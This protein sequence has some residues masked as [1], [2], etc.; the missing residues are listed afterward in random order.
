MIGGMT[1]SAP[2]ANGKAKRRHFARNPTSAYRPSGGSILGMATAALHG[3]PVFT[4]LDIPLM[5]RDP[6]VRFISALWRG[7]FQ[8]VRWKVRGS[9]EK[10]ANFVQN[11]LRRFWRGGVPRILARYFE[12]G[13]GAGGVEFAVRRGWVRL[14]KVRPL[15]CQDVEPRV[16]A[17]D[18]PAL[19][20]R[21]GAFAGVRVRGVERLVAPP[22]AM[23]FA[24]NQRFGEWYDQSPLS[25]MFRPWLE[26]N[27]RGGAIQQRVKWF[28][29]HASSGHTIRYPEGTTNVGPDENPEERN[30]QDLARETLDY[31]ETNSGFILSN[32]KQPTAD[33]KG[34]DYEWVIEHPEAYPDVA[35]FRDYPKDLD[36]EML[37]GAGI[38][39]EVVQSSE[40]GSGYNGRLLPYQGFLGTVDEL[41]GLLLEAC[42]PWLSPLV[43]VNFGP[44]AWYE[45]RPI[46]LADQ[47][48]AE[49]MKGQKRSGE[50]P[51]KPGM[52]GQLPFTLSTTTDPTVLDAI[53]QL[54]AKVDA[55]SA[56]PPA[57]VEM[58]ATVGPDEEAAKAEAFERTAGRLMRSRKSTIAQLLALAM[59][60]TQQRANAAG[61]PE[62]AAGSLQ[63]LSELAGDPVQVARI[64]GMKEMSATAAGRALEMAWTLV[65]SPGQQGYRGKR[66]KWYDP[67]H[68]VRYQDEQPGARREKREASEKAGWEILSKVVARK[69][70]LE[71]VA[72]LGTHLPVMRSKELLKARAALE[73]NLK[74]ERKKLQM[75]ERILDHVELQADKP[76]RQRRAPFESRNPRRKKNPLAG[77]VAQAV[78]DFGGIDPED[79][80]F[81][82]HYGS[83]KEALEDGIPRQVFRDKA[84]GKGRGG[85][86]A[87]AQ[88][89]HGSNLIRIPEDQSPTGYV[90]EQ[91]K[92]GGK[93]HDHDD[94]EESERRLQEDARQ[95]Q[96]AED[97]KLKQIEGDRGYP[98]AF[99]APEAEPEAEQEAEPAAKPAPEPAPEPEPEDELADLRRRADR[100]REAFRSYTGRDSKHR[101]FLGKAARGAA[102][103]LHAAGKG[104]AKGAPAPTPTPP[105]P[106]KGA[107]DEADRVPWDRAGA[108]AGAAAG[109]EPDRV[110]WDRAE[111]VPE[112]A[113]APEVEPETPAEPEKPKSAADEIKDGPSLAA[114]AT[115]RVKRLNRSEKEIDADKEMTPKE[116]A[117]RKA[118]IHAARKAVVTAAS[119]GEALADNANDA[120]AFGLYERAREAAEALPDA[121]REQ[122]LAV[123]DRAMPKGAVPVKGDFDDEDDDAPEPAEKTSV[124]DILAQEKDVLAKRR[125][126]APPKPAD[127]D[128]KAEEKAAGQTPEPVKEAVAEELEEPEAPEAAP[129]EPPKE[130]E[131]AKARKYGPARLRSMA[132]R[133]M[134]EEAMVVLNHPRHGPMKVRNHHDLG[135]YLAAGGRWPPERVYPPSVLGDGYTITPRMAPDEVKRVRG[136]YDERVR[137]AMREEDAKPKSPPPR[138]PK[139]PPKG[140]PV[141]PKASGPSDAVREAVAREPVRGENES[142]HDFF[143]RTLDWQDETS[144]AVM[145][146]FKAR[147]RALADAEP[148]GAVREGF[149]QLEHNSPSVVTDMAPV[150]GQTRRQRFEAALRG[151]IA[152]SVEVGRPHVERLG[153]AADLAKFDQAVARHKDRSPLPGPDEAAPPPEP[154]KPPK[155]SARAQEAEARMDRLR[156]HF[157]PGNVVTGYG[158]HDEVLG[159]TPNDD[160]T[161]SVR[162]RAV[163]R[164]GAG[165][166]PDPRARVRVHSTAPTEKE[167][168]AGPVG[169]AAGAAPVPLDDPEALAGAVHEAGKAVKDWVGKSYDPDSE[170][171]LTH[172]VPVADLY[173]AL[174]GRLPDGTTF[175]QFQ[176]ALRGARRA[177]VLDVARND[178]PQVL[179]PDDFG[180]MRRSATA[181]FAGDDP[182]GTSSF[183]YVNLPGARPKPAPA[184][185]ERKKRPPA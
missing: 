184:P 40:S 101:E 164:D 126:K 113:P 82:A 147:M 165:W 115:D 170:H 88:E 46:S 142:H 171:W 131:A 137:A 134:G 118:E 61:D 3:E 63:A 42:E 177:G 35:G 160:G 47:A 79:S 66:N 116:K 94:T 78:I 29:K 51:A 130:P 33:G 173:D 39:K 144:R 68:G 36:L 180:R 175:E 105:A 6:N 114:W 2:P 179:S 50:M 65:A 5:M 19:G 159:F 69:A 109:D 138:Q 81:R 43:E 135:E 117:A 104:R 23:W 64:V 174:K 99:D 89:L 155:K 21:A 122:M 84:G 121:R 151:A 128:L 7:P 149:L 129:P 132:E 120:R 49:Q 17:S 150:A 44:D 136:E 152:D 107:E 96:E 57:P 169:K 34:G 15:E 143:A 41:S 112:P 176:E 85:L 10:V 80:E 145:A 100:A 158:G 91:L 185:Y 161:F 162:V 102:M 111:T 58:A 76:D 53:R 108:G 25:G 45:V 178:L 1:T 48:E 181:N 156:A 183:H 9:D 62:A 56:P 16:W 31:A 4:W 55:L 18:D 37:A 90:L 168:R 140:K 93:S 75:V 98:A 74:G 60:K 72:E 139:K 22:H 26:K 30:N 167:L 28:R 27:G 8:K 71:E 125:A 52:G 92:G 148:P 11:T 97:A 32:A 182:H 157:T 67:E 87:L 86:D 59:V 124:K 110:A 133:I 106:A 54:A 154:K 24:G 119:L 12:H 153:T 13:F 38:P 172:K 20:R 127:P 163:V 73:V 83:V 146:D 77:T 123:L 14:A 95:Q 70:S 103:R 166:A 141:R